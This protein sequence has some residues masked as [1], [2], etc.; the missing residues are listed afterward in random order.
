MCRG[1]RPGLERERGEAILC[2]NQQKRKR[3]R[4]VNSFILDRNRCQGELGTKLFFCFANSA[5]ARAYYCSPYVRVFYQQKKLFNF[6][7]SWHDKP[8]TSTTTRT[9]AITNTYSGSRETHSTTTRQPLLLP[10]L[11]SLAR[12]LSE[13]S[14]YDVNWIF[15]QWDYVEGLSASNRHPYG[16]AMQKKSEIRCKF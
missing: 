14:I 7:F 5:T 10:T 15:N 13:R 8:Q 2:E 9:A 11:L 12:L 16:N 1:G 4:E 3:R 6:I